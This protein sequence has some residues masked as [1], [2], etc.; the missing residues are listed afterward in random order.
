MKMIKRSK[1][2][3]NEKILSYVTGLLKTPDKKSCKNMSTVL[4]LSH[5]LLT[6]FFLCSQTLTSML[7]GL[8]VSL[9]NKF[10]GNENRGYLIIDDTGI[11][12][13]YAKIIGGVHRVMNVC[14]GIP[15]QNITI[16]VLCWSNGMVTIPIGYKSWAPKKYFNNVADYQSKGDVALALINEAIRRKIP[17]LYLLADCHYS[18]ESMLARLN[19]LG[20]QFVMRARKNLQV[21]RGKK[22]Y[23]LDSIGQFCFAEKQ[24]RALVKAEWRGM[25]LYFSAHK[26]TDKNGKISIIYLLSNTKMKTK[27]YLATYMKRWKIEEMFRTLK[28]KLG[29]HH[30]TVQT[31]EKQQ[32][33]FDAAIFAYSF[34]QHLRHEK[35]FDNP[36]AAINYCRSLKPQ[37][38]KAQ[39]C[40]FQQLFSDVA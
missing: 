32:S 12:K 21:K 25:K 38:I 11:P 3:G 27:S 30:S 8:L 20:I 37:I 18:S 16:V 13:I 10:S 19:N 5:D 7:P 34:A 36:D 33:H 24:K 40:R 17:Y 39:L 26:R 29:I 31:L 2:E 1:K 14:L 6:R 15:Q 9:I 35:N 28:Q 4:G 22:S 23:R